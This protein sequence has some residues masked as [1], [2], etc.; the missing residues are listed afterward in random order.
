MQIFVDGGR[1]AP[2]RES[3]TPA[4]RLPVLGTVVR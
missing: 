2:G 3:N 1:K 4:E